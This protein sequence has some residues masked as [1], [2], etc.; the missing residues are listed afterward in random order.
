MLGHWDKLM[1]FLDDPHIPLDT[2]EIERGFRSPV[3]GRKNHYGSK[4]LRGTEV[5]A[6]FYSL[7]ESAK[8]C[9]INPQQYLLDATKRLLQDPKDILLPHQL[10]EL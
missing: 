8:L 7:I 10:M 3:V 4:S 9:G 1:L 5:A 2:N 6:I